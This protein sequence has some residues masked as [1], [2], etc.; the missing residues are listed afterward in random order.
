MQRR[1]FIKTTTA[2]TGS[3]LIPA[4]Q[5]ASPSGKDFYEMRVYQFAD[6]SGIN[7]LK[8]Y[9]T[10]AVIPLLNKNGAKVGV[11][12]E[13]SKEDPPKLYVLHI[14]KGVSEY[15]E[16]VQAMKSDKIFI[17]ASG[18]YFRQPAEKPVFER[19]ETVLMEA[20]DA[21]PRYKSPG[22]NRGLFELRTYES[23]NEEA[24][25][26][27]IKMF[28]L[29]EL[30]LFEEVGL[31]P[32]FFGEIVAGQFMPALRYM[33]W[34]RNMEEREANWNKFRTSNKWTTMRDKAE[35]ANT[36]SK[37]R[38]IFLTPLDISQI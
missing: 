7:R 24:L 30:P 22:N 5:A 12:G 4:N 14:H 20:F 28:N 17:E 6:G 21:I 33:L 13:Y 19:Y 15:W 9:Y 34:F 25:G 18:D 2:A 29:E 26:R 37:V 16:T 32:L 11:F 10:E 8:K 38:K 27:K 36:V 35:Y 3:L 31:H 23:Y 1:T